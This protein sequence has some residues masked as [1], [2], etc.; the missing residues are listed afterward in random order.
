MNH[1]LAKFRHKLSENNLDAM[2]VAQPQNR[3][4]LS[5]FTADDDSPAS[6]SAWLIISQDKA[7]LLTS[8]TNLEWAK[9]EVTGFDF[10]NVPTKYT[11]TAADLLRDLPGKRIG[12]ESDYMPVATHNVLTEA[13]GTD[14]ELV[15]TEGLVEGLRQVKSEEEINLIA[16]A[17]AIADEA[18]ARVMAG[19]TV[20]QT[21]EEIAWELEKY[22]REHG[23]EGI[24][25]DTIVAA[26]PNSALPHSR[27]SARPIRAGEPVI[28]D[29][30][31]R[32][33][34]YCSDITRTFSV[35]QPDER[36]L[37][38]YSVVLEALQASEAAIRPG[39]TGH[40]VDAVARQIIANAGYGDAFGHG[41]GHGVGLAIHEKPHLSKTS[42][43][44][45]AENM[46]VT[47][48]PGI[49]IPG[50]GGVRVEDSVVIRRDRVEILTK[51][52]KQSIIPAM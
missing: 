50:W 41:L 29:V 39:M 25:F 30:G 4:Y 51:T 23:A 6:P 10:V 9:A 37:K 48:E 45:L 7:M 32:V 40:E 31:A 17:A 46:V 13:L 1:R 22:M 2:L 15:P 14:K 18:L 16:E 26:G 20:G 35:G 5:G 33:G 19:A 27:V 44:V 24:A 3:R 38:V 21:E 49:Y 42:E 8:F 43:D 12:F 28:I 34:G 36:F 52:S 47:V 11:L